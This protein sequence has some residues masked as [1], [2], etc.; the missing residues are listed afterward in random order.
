MKHNLNWKQIKFLI[1]IEL[2]INGTYDLSVLNLLSANLFRFFIG[3]L[4]FA[5]THY[6]LTAN[7]QTSTKKGTQ[8]AI[9]PLVALPH[10]RFRFSVT[11]NKR[12]GKTSKRTKYFWA[13]PCWWIKRFCVSYFDDKKF[14]VSL[15]RTPTSKIQV[16]CNHH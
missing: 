4:C 8:N 2:V 12:E 14:R 15:S 3:K 16:F 9:I 10:L 7:L 6:P 5:Q 1:L 11:Y 13:F